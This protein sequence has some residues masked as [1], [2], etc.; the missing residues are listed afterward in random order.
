M[1]ICDISKILK[2]WLQILNLYILQDHIPECM[3]KTLIALDARDRVICKLVPGLSS[4]H[5]E[6]KRQEIKLKLFCREKYWK[7]I[8]R[9]GKCAGR[10]LI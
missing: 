6:E 7:E 10:L 3:Y 8:S 1:K 5:S 9:D 2:L 4:Q